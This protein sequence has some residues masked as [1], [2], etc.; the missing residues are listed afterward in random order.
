MHLCE[1]VDLAPLTTMGVGGAA[2]YFVEA[3][4]PDE[5]REAVCWAR[6]RNLPLFVLGGGSNL[7]VADAGFPGLALRV[8]ISGVSESQDGNRVLLTAGAGE[9]WDRFVA[10]AV[11]HNWGGLEC[12]SGIPGTVGATPVQN[13]GAYGQEVG[14]SIQHVDVLEIESGQLS[15]MPR[16]ECG[17]GYRT[18][19]FNTR[20][21]G[22]Y[23]ILRVTFALTPN[24][25]PQLSYADLRKRLGDRTPS[26]QETRDTVLEI[27]R[28][29]GMLLVEGDPNCHSAGSF[30]Q[31]PV[32]TAERYAELQERCA[33]G[34]SPFPAIPPRSRG[35]RSPRP[36]WWSRRDFTRDTPAELPAF[37]PNMPWP[38]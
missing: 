26:L 8:A 12:L 25:A 27:R 4:N 29:K 6:T 17:F 30:F 2:R 18:S 21:R 36:G 16:E 7:V 32:L 10:H 14:H 24:A 11:G 35:I 13:V 19:I 33:K 23:I 20:A 31:N 34:I 28:A 1:N 5:V 38:S 3:A 22:R 9:D 37:R 15:T